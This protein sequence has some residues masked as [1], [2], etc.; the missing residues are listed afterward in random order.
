MCVIYCY[1]IAHFLTIRHKLYVSLIISLPQG[2][3][4][5]AKNK[6]LTCSKENYKIT[7]IRLCMTL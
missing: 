1:G 7:A 3:V 5:Y 2:K 6:F 4:L